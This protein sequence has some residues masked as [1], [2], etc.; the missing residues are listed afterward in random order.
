[1]KKNDFQKRK[2]KENSH[3]PRNKAKRGKRKET[4]RSRRQLLTAQ[5]LLPT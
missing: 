1:M 4:E 2:E 5:L 3:E